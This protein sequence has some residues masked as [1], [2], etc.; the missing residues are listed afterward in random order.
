MSTVL[1]EYKPNEVKKS[2]TAGQGGFEI[3]SRPECR[4][5]FDMQ[6]S[7]LTTDG[8]LI[9]ELSGEIDLQHS[10][11]MRQLLQARA[12]QRIPALLLDFTGV[13]YIDSSGLA[14]LIEYY[15]SS[16]AYDGKII[17]AGLSH[18]V[19]SIFELVRLNEV[20]PIYATVLE[21]RQALQQGLVH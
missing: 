7:E 13:K 20:F 16:R 4:Y 11:E 15:Q 17:V 2:P 10:P 19:R 18:R 14:T 1:Q 8:V 12:A 3:A 9:L 6:W 21:A 5:E